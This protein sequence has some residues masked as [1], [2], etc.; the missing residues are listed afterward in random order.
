[1]Q[2]LLAVRLVQDLVQRDVLRTFHRMRRNVE[3]VSARRICL[4]REVVKPQNLDRRQRGAVMP[5]NWN[6]R[7]RGAVTPHNLMST[8]FRFDQEFDAKLM[9]FGSE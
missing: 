7:L 4:S 8:L 1:M 2:H 6:H 3:R 5:Q 9:G